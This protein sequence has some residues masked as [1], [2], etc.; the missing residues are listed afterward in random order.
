VRSHYGGLLK[1]GLA[2]EGPTITDVVEMQKVIS[3]C[4]IAICNRYHSHIF[5]IIQ[6]V[7]FVSIGGTPKVRF[8]MEDAGFTSNVALHP[9]EIGR[10]LYYTLIPDVHR[11]LVAQCKQ[12]AA[13]FRQALSTLTIPLQKVKSLDMIK[14]E[15]CGLFEGGAAAEVVAGTILYNI[16]G[17]A[18]NKYTYGFLQNLA[19]GVHKLEDMI[20]WVFQDHA[21]SKPKISGIHL[22]QTSDEFS[23]IHR[24]GWEFVMNMMKS[25]QTTDGILCDAYVDS[26]FLWNEQTNLIQGVIPIHR[27]WIGFLHHTFDTIYSD[28]NLNTLFAKD[29]FIGSLQQCKGL[30]TLSEYLRK[31]VAARLMSI[32]FT[33]IPVF[34]I[35]HPT[36]FT[37]HTFSIFGFT[38]RPKIVQIGAWLRDP[39]AIYHVNSH[40]KKFVLSGPNMGFYR[41]PASVVIKNGTN[42]IPGVCNRHVKANHVHLVGGVPTMK[43]G[44]RCNCVPTDPN[45]NMGSVCRPGAPAIG[46]PTPSN[47]CVQFMLGYLWSMGAPDIITVNDGTFGCNCHNDPP[48]KFDT[49]VNKLNAAIASNFS[50]VEVIEKLQNHD[51]DKLLAHSVVFVKLEDA[52][53]VNTVIEC[54]MRNTPII[55]NRHPAVV[56][57]LGEHYPLYYDVRTT[58]AGGIAYPRVDISD[59]DVARIKDAHRYLTNLD[60]TPIAI[61]TFISALKSVVAGL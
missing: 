3:G 27:P 29:S 46:R 35:M 25:I 41:H 20:E 40:C 51:Y 13:N 49:V 53:A 10:A 28:N 61:D 33:Q 14:S 23:G 60:K 47:M 31:A 38:S 1:A 19:T 30:I 34:T 9:G 59:I 52:S 18:R 22:L 2:E 32:G 36:E 39:Y 5:S 7:P 54:I 48:R 37:S 6:G 50:S 24:S 15:A 56:E 58:A 21:Q 12:T 55:I 43:C 16:T 44:S 26:T 11:A 45:V 17:S 8:L 57:Y 4:H 42:C